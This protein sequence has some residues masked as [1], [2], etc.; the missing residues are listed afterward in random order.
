MARPEK[1]NRRFWHNKERNKM[2]HQWAQ[3]RTVAPSWW[4]GRRR[5]GAHGAVRSRRAAVLCQGRRT[6]A[7]PVA[8]AALTRARR[9]R[10]A[11]CGAIR[12]SGAGLRRRAARRAVAAQSTGREWADIES[13]CVEDR[14]CYWSLFTTF[15]SAVQRHT[16]QRGTPSV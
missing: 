14:T 1:G 16:F 4:A 9:G 2:Q 11:A 12:S 7:T 8:S 6:H 10:Q 15:A 5:S 3:K 13:S